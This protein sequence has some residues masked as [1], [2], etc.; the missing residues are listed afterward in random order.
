MPFRTDLL[1]EWRRGTDIVVLLQPLCYWDHRTRQ[2]IAVPT[3]FD[4]DG[5]SIPR[6]PLL[7]S[8]IGHPFSEQYRD[9]AVLHDFLYRCLVSRGYMRKI[10]ADQMFY[11]AMRELGCPCWKAQAI[12]QAV[13]QFG[14]P[15]TQEELTYK[16]SKK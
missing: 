1:T 5:A 16:R 12:Y 7:W 8:I 15:L 14:T 6:F 11:D 9:A 13:R 2:E 10:V 3:G 4:S